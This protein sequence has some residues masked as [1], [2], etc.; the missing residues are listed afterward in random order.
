MS[1]WWSPVRHA[2]GVPAAPPDLP[3]D[4]G[5]FTEVVFRGALRSSAGPGR[6]SGLIERFFGMR[7]GGTRWVL[8]TNRRLLVL[9]RRKPSSYAADEWFDVSLDRRTIRAS[10]PF[11]EGSLVVMAM[12]TGKGPMSLLL[13][14]K[15]FKEA[16][17]MARTLGAAG[18]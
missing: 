16:E 9:R 7:L 11:M 3:L 1:T 15:A 12:V 10:M 18:R 4:R 17:R 6:V 13:P 8:L 5:E 2:H 14:G